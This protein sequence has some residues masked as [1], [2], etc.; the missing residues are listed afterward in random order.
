MS[1]FCMNRHPAKLRDVC[2]FLFDV[3][4]PGLLTFPGWFCSV[5]LFCQNHP[6]CLRDVA[7]S[8]FY[9][10]CSI[11]KI[12]CTISC[13]GCLPGVRQGFVVS[14][15][16]FDKTIPLVCGMSPIGILFNV[17]HLLWV[18]QPTIYVQGILI[19]TWSKHGSINTQT[20]STFC[21]KT[22]FL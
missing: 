9:L 4:H 19:C 22:Y 1:P 20:P 12:Q 10:M 3:V 17:L 8:V 7:K 6:A 21:R 14:C 16:Y 13:S 15:F 2:L 18:N 5:F 11:P